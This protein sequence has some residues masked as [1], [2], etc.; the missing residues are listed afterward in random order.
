[1][2]GRIREKH[3]KTCIIANMRPENGLPVAT[4]VDAV[5]TESPLGTAPSNRWPPLGFHVIER[6]ARAGIPVLT[7]EYKNILI[8]K[9]EDTAENLYKNADLDFC[10]VPQSLTKWQLCTRGSQ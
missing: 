9:Y 3:P 6:V 8:S 10:V 4:S 5:F 7:V 2:I 1:M